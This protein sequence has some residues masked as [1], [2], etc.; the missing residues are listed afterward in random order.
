METFSALLTLCAGPG[1][2]PAQRPVTW[3]FD[4]SLIYACINDWVNNREA[5]YLRRHRGHYDVI[6][7][8]HQGKTKNRRPVFTQ[9]LICIILIEM[10]LSADKILLFTGHKGGPGRRW[11]TWQ[12]TTPDPELTSLTADLYNNQLQQLNAEPWW[13]DGNKNKVGENAVCP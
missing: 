11:T 8:G 3:T 2:F 1:E 5:G 9:Y 4:I 6:V 12:M 10:S 13:R 7:M